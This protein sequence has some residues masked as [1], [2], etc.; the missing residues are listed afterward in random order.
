MQIAV[1]MPVYNGEKFLKKAINSLLNQTYR[2]FTFYI[3][4]DGSKD[5]TWGILSAYNDKR[6]VLDQNKNNLGLTR[7]LNSII[8]S[9]TEDIIIRMD[10]DDIS[11]PDR[12]KK[13]LSAFQIGQSIDLVTSW[14]SIIDKKDRFLRHT[15]ESRIDEQLISKYFSLFNFFSH[16]ACAFKRNAFNELGGYDESFELSQDYQLW[17]KFFLAKKKIKIINEHLYYIRKHRN[18]LSFTKR[19]TQFYD[20]LK[21]SLELDEDRYFKKYWTKWIINHYNPFFAEL[22][23]KAEQLFKRYLVLKTFLLKRKP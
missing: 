15:L 4:D 2:E 12:I 22:T 18:S 23:I 16:G 11:H 19:R 6:I 14:A 17:L 9:L 3:T 8:H 13:I 10:A 21:I 5:N 20:R 7:V 1:V